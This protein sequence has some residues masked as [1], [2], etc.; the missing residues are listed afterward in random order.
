VAAL[1]QEGLAGL[2]DHSWR[3]A[4]SL[5]GIVISEPSTELAE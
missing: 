4:D 1:L 2:V 5:H 3:L